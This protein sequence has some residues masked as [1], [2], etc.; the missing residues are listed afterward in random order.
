MFE[1]LFKY[2]SQVFSRGTFVLAGGWPV[3]GLIACMVAAA[4]F[5]AWM[6]LRNP[7]GPARVQGAKSVA[8][9][10]LQTALASLLLLMLW[11]PALS[12]ATLRPQQNIVAVVV[13][14]SSSMSV[15]DSGNGSRRGAALNVLNSGLLENLQKR[16]QVRLYKFS[17]HLDRITKLETLNSSGQSTHI[18]ESLKQVLADAS[19]LPIGA[20]VLMSDGADNSGGIDLETIQE[21][22]RQRIPVHTVGFGRE[23]MAHDIE[24]SDVQTPQ[25]ALPDSRLSA[26]VSFHQHGYAGQKAKVTLKDGG[27]V[28]AVRE[29][30]LKGDGVEQ[31]EAL[32]FNAGSAGVKT[33]ETSV[34]PLPGEENTKNNK[35]TRLVN[36]D[37]RKPRILYM[38][39]EPRWEFKFLRRAVEDDQ[40]I[41]LVTIL[42]TTQNKIYVQGLNNDDKEIKDGFP[43]KVETLFGFDG[44]IIGSSEAAYFTTT[45]QQLIHDFVD[46][47]GGGLL[48]L[49]G[50]DSLADG[51]YAKSLFTDLLPVILPDKKNTFQRVYPED[52]GTLHNVATVE[53]TAAGRDSL[54][55]RLEEDPQRNVERWKKL[56]YLMNFELPGQPKPGAVVLVD[57]IVNGNR[58]PLLITQNFGRGRTAVFATG[59][60]WRWRMLLPLADKAH[61][62]FYTQLLR[63]LVNDT[64]RRVVASTPQQVLADES[65]VKL[66]AQVRD[67]TYLPSSDATV[68]AH[69]LG[70]EGLAEGV[71]MTPDPLEQGS[72]TA[73]YTTPKPGSYLVEM[74]AKRGAEELGRDTLTFRREDG[75]A[76]N[77]RVE[78]NRELL[79][80]LASETGGKY[81]KAD[82]ASK[83][84]KDISYSEAGIT[85]RETRDLWDMPAVFLLVLMLR[86]GEWLL[87]RKWGVI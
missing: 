12:V 66:H 9:W 63:W 31:N 20:V 53:L 64:P 32:V 15:D 7:A 46:R 62:M 23:K 42:R 5:F 84:G 40:D 57:G 29:V 36:V 10:L 14:D 45:Q 56:P 59:G 38:E 24:L 79:E 34:D 85:V 75:V 6:L 81:Y 21:I 2:P 28:L 39:G 82:E 76:E 61:S 3:W 67:R 86:S 27:K 77:F 30:T 16:F 33:I 48:F 60:S 8:V 51:G 17:D 13:D 55:T 47:R 22:R 11:H 26:E 44:L 65:H 68:E 37:Q 74:I 72:Y 18:G 58:F 71:S 73:D 50:K 70:P 49:G 35:L 52:N 78:Q 4:A 83:L 87:R 19:S 80:K 43:N 25:R 54:I 41:N 69:I 1:L